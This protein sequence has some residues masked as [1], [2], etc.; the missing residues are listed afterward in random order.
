M[1]VYR[2]NP[3]G[4][5]A[6]FGEVLAVK[7]CA[8][9]ARQLFNERIASIACADLRHPMGGF[10][11]YDKISLVPLSNEDMREDRRRRDVLLDLNPLG[12]LMI[13]TG[14][15]VGSPKATSADDWLAGPAEYHEYP[16]SDI[17]DPATLAMMLQRGIFTL[18]LVDIENLDMVRSEKAFGRLFAE[19]W[20]PR[21][22]LRA[23]LQAAK[24]R[25]R[26]ILNVLNGKEPT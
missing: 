24:R 8:E 3:S 15:E 20:S 21:K 18:R 5:I 22:D 6:E 12:S 9:D 25:G 11:P 7:V 2:C 13:F 10:E 16:V 19:H 17:S 1:D 14:L 26:A 23:R 4:Q